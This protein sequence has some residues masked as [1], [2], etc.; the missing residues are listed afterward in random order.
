MKRKDNLVKIKTCMVT[1]YFEYYDVQE[2]AVIETRIRGL[3]YIK[4]YAIVI[5]DRDLLESG[6]P[7][8]KHFHIV[9]TFSDTTTIGA[10]AKGLKVESQYVEKIKTTT[11]S[12]LLYLVHRNDPDKFQY[13]PE[14]VV[15]SFDYVEYVDGCKPKIK[16]DSIA[17]RISNWE[18]KQYNICKFI[19]V[20]EFATNKPYYDKCFIYRQNKLRTMDRELECLF[21]TGA[22]HTGKTTFAKMIANAKGF[23]TY[24][25][26]GG[27]HPLD[28]YEWQECII[29]DDLRDDTYS[30]AD[31]LKLTDNNTDSLVGCRFYNK[32]ISECKLLIATSVQDIHDFYK[33]E[34]SHDSKESQVQLFRRFK[35]YFVMDGQK[36]SAYKFMEAFDDY[37][38]VEE[39]INPV[40]VMFDDT[41]QKDFFSWIRDTLKIKTYQPPKE[42][43]DSA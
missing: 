29:L 6:E 10:V 28:N 9:L 37:T 38:L 3:T 43:Q 13:K 35:N 4:S 40:S 42:C 20:D 18:I 19:S 36:V 30:L 27:K 16:R 41:V 26:S 22:S 17:E 25:S 24:I 1:Q 11:K 15:A 33:Y 2:I 5:H 7:K 39:V 32:S 12:A 34:T 14:E 8:K 23:V 21:I 31:F